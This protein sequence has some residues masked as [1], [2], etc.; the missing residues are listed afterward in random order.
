[1]AFK[2]ILPLHKKDEEAEE[3]HHH[4]HEHRQ[5]ANGHIVPKQSTQKKRQR[6]ITSKCR[7]ELVA[8]TAEFCGTFLFLFFA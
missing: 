1:M 7:N 8:M 5:R 3:K 2:N 6:G 4:Q